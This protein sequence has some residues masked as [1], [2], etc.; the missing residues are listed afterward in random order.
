MI[1]RNSFDISCEPILIGGGI[2]GIM[3]ATFGAG[4]TYA[5]G[6]PAAAESASIL[7][8]ISGTIS[9]GTAIAFV[10]GAHL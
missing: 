10:K 2:G 1:S 9:S 4:L 6:F 3:S 5:V 8:G 7:F